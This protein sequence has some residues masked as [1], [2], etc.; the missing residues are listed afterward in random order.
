MRNDEIL[1]IYDR[2]CPA[3]SAYSQIVRIRESVGDL[4]LINAREDGEIMQEITAQGL[5]IDQGMVLKMAGQYYY[6]AQ[7]VHALALISSRAGAVNRINYWIFKSSM[8][9]K[10]LYPALR[11]FRNLLLK[12][13]GK[14]K[15]N[16]LRIK[17]NSKF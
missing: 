1:L 7:A 16:N 11:F 5:D 8:R 2:E 15:I 9:S 10:F 17:G 13:L 14:S 6:G 4:R 3:C 12:V